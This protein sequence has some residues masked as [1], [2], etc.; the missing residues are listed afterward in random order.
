MSLLHRI[1]DSVYELRRKVDSEETFV[2]RTLRTHRQDGGA[3]LLDVGCGFGRFHDFVVNAGWRYTGVD[4]SPRAVERGRAAGRDIRAAGDP[5]ASQFQSDEKFAAILFAH[6]IEHFDTDSLIPFLAGYLE[7]LEPG[8]I[9]VILT[10]LMH[11]GFYDDFDHV[12]PYNPEAIRQMFC[13]STLQTRPFELPGEYAE[14]DLW[15]K[16]DPFWH[17]Y[18]T[19]RINHVLGIPLTIACVASFGLIAKTTGYGMV[20]RRTR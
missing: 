2:R 6:V 19:R 1:V 13:R 7:M 9:V 17:S 10:P 11:R 3:R 14:I 8:G 20:L 5:L 12:K 15:I 16:R 4:L 18:R